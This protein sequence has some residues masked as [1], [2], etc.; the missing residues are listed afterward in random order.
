M[1]CIRS[2]TNLIWKDLVNCLAAVAVCAN[3]IFF[4]FVESSRVESRCQY[5]E[6]IGGWTTK[7]DWIFVYTN[8]A[9]TIF[10]HSLSF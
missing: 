2:S 7:A 1:K 10:G 9:V 4:A 6:I 3:S 5:S 8:F